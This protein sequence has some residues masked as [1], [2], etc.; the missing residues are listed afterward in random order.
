MIYV[1]LRYPNNTQPVYS[2]DIL[3]Y[4]VTF[5]IWLRYHGHL[6]ELAKVGTLRQHV[7]LVDSAMG[8]LAQL[9]LNQIRTVARPNSPQLK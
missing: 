7:R 3:Q 5:L 1:G 2:R 8:S 4:Q 9:L 6:A